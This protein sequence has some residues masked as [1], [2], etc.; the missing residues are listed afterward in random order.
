MLGYLAQ[1]H[2]AGV[3]Q[4][5]DP[6]KARD[7]R[8]RRPRTRVNKDALAFQDLVGNTHAM[9]A[10]EAGVAAVQMQVLALLDL[11]FQSGAPFTDNLILAGHDEG[12]VNLDGAGPDSP[13][14]GVARVVRHLS[15]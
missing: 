6:V 4:V 12:Q 7:R 3:G 1:L 9:R 14:A 2:D 11:L 10:V 15:R 5:G 13:A 8:A